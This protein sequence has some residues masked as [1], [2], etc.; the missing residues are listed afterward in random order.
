[1]ACNHRIINTEN[2]LL[3]ACVENVERKTDTT[4]KKGWIP[5]EWM[6]IVSTLAFSMYAECNATNAT[7]ARTIHLKTLSNWN[8]ME[9]ECI[10]E[11]IC[12][13]NE[14]NVIQFDSMLCAH[15]LTRTHTPPLNECIRL[16]VRWV[17]W[18]LKNS[19]AFFLLFRSRRIWDENELFF[20]SFFFVE[21]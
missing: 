13:T 21:S 11:Q 17:V 6:D 4:Y 18:F 9:N 15:S 2:I 20:F 19:K 10:N 7:H 12:P 16:G 5:F 14:N 8:G 3:H 1:M